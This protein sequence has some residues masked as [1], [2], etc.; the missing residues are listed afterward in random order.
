MVGKC[1]DVVPGKQV[2]WEFV[3]GPLSGTE[4]WVVE[5]LE[6]QCSIIITS[7]ANLTALKDLL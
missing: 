4:S 7:E 2:V 1:I 5:P 3:E 6:T